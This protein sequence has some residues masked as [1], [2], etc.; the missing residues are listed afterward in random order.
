MAS[1]VDFSKYLYSLYR[2]RFI[3]T[4]HLY[5]ACAVTSH[6][7]YNNYLFQLFTVVGFTTQVSAKVSRRK[8]QE[9]VE[10]LEKRVK[11]C[12]LQNKQLQQKVER[13]EKMNQYVTY[14]VQNQVYQQPTYQ[15]NT[16]LPC[17]FGTLCSSN[18][19]RVWSAF[20]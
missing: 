11:I 6:F 12:T 16:L 9:Y 8:K 19:Y 1:L 3:V 17:L 5:S 10:G 7:R 15:Y 14:A 4:R 18:L 20:L 13:L 2:L